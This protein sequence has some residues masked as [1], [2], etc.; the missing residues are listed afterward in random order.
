MRWCL[1][2][3]ADFAPIDV[4]ADFG[5]F[6]DNFCLALLSRDQLADLL[7]HVN[8]D[9]SWNVATAFDRYLLGHLFTNSLSDVLALLFGDRSALLLRHLS[10]LAIWYLP[11]KFLA[12]GVGNVPTFPTRHI[13]A[14]FSGNV[15]AFLSGYRDR[16]GLAH[17]L[18]QARTLLSGHL[19]FH[20]LGDSFGDALA[21]LFL[22]VTTLPLRKMARDL[23]V[24]QGALGNLDVLTDL[25][26]HLFGYIDALLLG[27]GRAGF[28]GDKDG[29][30]LLHLLALGS[31]DLSTLLNGLI[32]TNLSLHRLTNWCLRDTIT[33]SRLGLIRGDEVVFPSAATA[34]AIIFGHGLALGLVLGLAF[35]LGDLRTFLNVLGLVFGLDLG[36]ALLHVLR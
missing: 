18:E 30:L 21:V 6:F 19:L 5:T 14:G 28:S 25:A 20:L 10:T 7:R 3:V 33:V 8:A 24:D 16:D 31:L 23:P 17:L 11:D 12:Y 32:G 29:L 15:L 22:N 34:A 9:L 27:Y 1:F 26:G 13:F 2:S 36:L 4:L 35:G